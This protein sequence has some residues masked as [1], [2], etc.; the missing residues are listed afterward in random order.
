[1]INCDECNGECCR[2]VTV[3][4]DEPENMEDWQDIRW[5]VV[6]NNVSVYLD[7]EGDWVVEF[8][9]PCVKLDKDN[10]CTMYTNRPVMCRNHEL[11]SCIKNGEGDLHKIRFD[12]IEEV[13]EYIEKVV[14]PQMEMQKKL[15][16][17]L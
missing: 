8:K 4:L 3:G 14:K 11:D 13:D 5:M 17:D 15:K 2:D 9:T 7:E 6:H 12:T 1:M 10:K 16:K